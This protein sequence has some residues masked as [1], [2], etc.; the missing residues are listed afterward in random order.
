MLCYSSYFFTKLTWLLLLHILKVFNFCRAMSADSLNSITRPIPKPS[1]FK[2]GKE[3]GQGTFSTVYVVQEISTS[4]EFAMK[5]VDK[6]RVW[7]YKAVDSVLMEKE[8]LKRTNHVFIIR[9]HCTF[10]DSTRL[11]YLLEYAR[12]GELLSY[13]TYFTSLSVHCTRFY[14]AEIFAALDYLHSMSIVHRDLKPE[15]VLLTDKMHIKLA[16]FGSAV[17]LNS[18]NIK[19]PS[20]T[21]TPE[22]VSPEMLSRISRQGDCTPNSES[23][24]DLTYLMDFWAFG[25]IIYQLISGS[26]PFRKSGPVHEYETFQKILSLSYTFAPNFDPIAKDLVEKLLV[27]SPSERLGSPSH[28]GSI[29]VRRHMFFSEIKWDILPYQ[30]P[31]LL[32]PNLEP[33]AP[34]GWDNLPVGFK[35]AE[36]YHLSRELGLSPSQITEDDRIRLLNA[37]GKHNPFN[38]FVRG[39]LILKQGIL[40]KRRGLFARKRMFLLTEGPHLFY[41]DV[42]NMT[43][44]GEVAWSDSLTVELRSNKLF[45]IHVPNKTYYLEDPSGHADDWVKQITSVRA[46]YFKD[47]QTLCSNDPSTSIELSI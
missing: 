18:P 14:A 30:E 21:G 46:R 24:Q 34:E 40:F 47:T 7:R 41:I 42:E 6:Q 12:C 10:Q 37:Q 15:N 5:V 17:I 44:K 3:I 1:D 31:P 25:C 45:F 8:V 19:A 26:S 23:S 39:R 16:D 29:S 35:E 13:L 11:F 22:Y 33:I 38:R 28:G 9:L 43:L 4:S 32:V 36:K 20:F 27:I 2:F